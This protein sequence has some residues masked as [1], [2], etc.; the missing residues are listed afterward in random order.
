M[1]SVLGIKALTSS[2]KHLI[3]GMWLHIMCTHQFHSQLMDPT[4]Q[5]CMSDH[6]EFLFEVCMVFTS[7]PRHLTFS[8]WL[9]VYIYLCTNGFHAPLVVLIPRSCMSNHV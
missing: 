4:P 3:F 2:S 5:S 6:I 8:M 7:S 1:D 9:Y